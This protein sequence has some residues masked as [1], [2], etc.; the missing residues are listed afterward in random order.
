MGV[1]D[2]YGHNNRS[3]GEYMC[4]MAYSIDDSQLRIKFHPNAFF[5]TRTD[6]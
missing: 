3:N 4:R 2:R 5:I 6:I 1:V